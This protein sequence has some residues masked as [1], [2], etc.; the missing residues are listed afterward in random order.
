MDIVGAR[1]RVQYPVPAVMTP[2]GPELLE[3]AQTDEEREDWAEGSDPRQVTSGVL[4]GVEP[5]ALAFTS[6]GQRNASP[7]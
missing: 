7:I 2:L 6:D 5:F 4:K 3:A 1:G